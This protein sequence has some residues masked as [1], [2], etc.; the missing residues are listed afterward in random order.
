M[1]LAAGASSDQGSFGATSLKPSSSWEAGGSSGTFSWSYPI[2]TP[3]VAGSLSPDLAIGYS[4][5]ATDGAVSTTNNQASWLGEGFDLPVGFIERKF[6]TC[7]LETTPK[8][9]GNQPAGNEDLCW[10]TE[11]ART[12]NAKYDNAVLSLQGHS[13]A[14]IRVGNTTAWRLQ[15]DDGTR[16]EKIG[17]IAGG[18]ESW[19]VT[20]PDGTQ[21]FFGKGKADGADAPA[22]NSVLKVPVAGNHSGE[23]GYTAGA[24]ASSFT[25][26]PYRWNL[27]YVVATTGDTMTFYYDKETNRYNR[28]GATPASYDRAATLTGIFYGERKGQEA[29]NP[30][31]KVTF[32]TAERC[33]PAISA[34]CATA[35]PTTATMAAWPDVPMDA[36]CSDEFC[37]SIKNAPTFFT[38]KK[39]TDITTWVQHQA[40]NGYDKVDSWAIGTGFPDSGDANS[41]ATLWPTTITQTGHTGPA[42][43]ATLTLP[44]V[45][46][47]PVFKHNRIDGPSGTY[48][49]LRP[50]LARIFSEAGAVTTVTYSDGGC[51]P[52]TLPASAAT[53]TTR[54]FPNYYSATPGDT[55]AVNWFSKYVVT[56]VEEKD[57]STDFTAMPNLTGLDLST[58]RLTSYTYVGSAAWHWDD[59]I[60][61]PGAKGTWNSW[62]G[63]QKVVTAVGKSGAPQSVTEKT[64][65][66]GMYGDRKTESGSTTKTDT[67][68]D[69]AGTKV[70]DTGSY[71]GQLRESRVLK[72]VGGSA[73]S[74]TIYDPAS[75]NVSGATDGL[76]QVA[77][78]DIKTTKTTQYLASGSRTRTTTVKARDSWGQPTQ[79]EDSG[80]SA[81][82]GDETC[83]RTTYATPTGTATAIDL[84]AEESVMPNV[85]STTLATASVISWEKSLYDGATS[86]GGV[87]GPG[88][89]TGSQ[90]LTGSSTR[91]W[92][93]ETTTSF[94]QHGRPVSVTDALGRTTTTTY[95]PATIKAPT[96]TEV[97]SPDPDGT[98]PAVP[99]TGTVFTD[100]RRNQQIKSISAAGEISEADR[101]A[102]GRVT[103]TWLPGRPRTESA[104]ATYSYTMNVNGV[105]TI[106]TNTLTQT[107]NGL[108]YIT[109]VDLLDSLLRPRQTQTQSLSNGIIV[110][111]NFYDSRGLVALT[112]SYI[113]DVSPG[114]TLRAADVWGDVK[115]NVRTVRDY[116]G[117]PLTESTY[118]GSTLLWQTSTVYGGNT[119]KVT[120]PTGGTPTTTTTD[121]QGRTTKL[122]QHL[123]ADSI[124]SYTYTPA[125]AI[126][127]MTDPKGNKWSYTYDLQGNQLTAKDPD[128]G[129]TTSTYNAVNQP[130][131]VKDARNLGV[132]YTYDA[133]DRVTQTTNLA[134][135][136][137][138]TAATFDPATG[139]PASNT[140]YVT[141]PTTGTPVAIQ[142]SIDSYDSAGRATSTTLH[143][144]AITN[145]VPTQL[146]GDYTITNT[147][148]P[149]GQPATTGLPATGPVA[150]ETLTHGYNTYGAPYSLTGAATYVVATGYYQTNDLAGINMGSVPGNIIAAQY[151]HDQ[152]SGRLTSIR[153]VTQVQAGLIDQADYTYDPA[154]NITN[155]KSSLVGGIIDNQCFSYDT[156]RQLKAAWTTPDTG[157]CATTPTQTTLGNGPAPYWSTWT[158]DTIGKTSSRTDKTAT[159][160]ATTTYTYPANSATAVRPHSVTQTVT[161]GTGAATRTYTYDAAGNTL[162]R[163]GPT[164]A[165]QTLTYDDEGKLT[166]VATG[167]T[168]N[169]VMVYDPTGNRIINQEGTQTTL[170]VAGTELTYDTATSATTASRYYTH[171]GT[172]VAVR[173]GNTPDKL[174]S[175]IT[176]H[177]NTPHHQIRNSDS[178]V[179]ASWQNPYGTS[180][181][182]APTTWTGKRGFVGGSNDTTGLIHIGA[183]DY[184]PQLQRFTTVDPVQNTTDPLQWNPY[185]Y[186]QNTPVTLSDPTGEL[187]CIDSCDWDRRRFDPAVHAREVKRLSG[188]WPARTPKRY[189]RWGY[190]ARPKAAFRGK[191]PYVS[192]KSS[193]KPEPRKKTPP[194]VPRVPVLP[195][196]QSNFIGEVTKLVAQTAG[197]TCTREGS[198]NVCIGGAWWL[199]DNQRS[200]GAT[201]GNTFWTNADYRKILGTTEYEKLMR[202][203]D[204]HRQQWEIF[205]ASFAFLYTAAEISGS[206]RDERLGID[207]GCSNVF[208][209]FAGLSDGGYNC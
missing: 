122:T 1:A 146:A 64:W 138:F 21:Y 106:T 170:T 86:S 166:K 19:K 33:D 110:A 126:A 141:D 189:K 71:T 164:G 104:S 13:G 184:D 74:S 209:I 154:G 168:T 143:L 208:E 117:R 3:D 172:T 102:F 96:K 207:A 145:L 200:G 152:A 162:T 65:Y 57:I 2:A 128:K 11:S 194:P 124:T 158:T 7:G 72:S 109:S 191:N 62:R 10:N 198:M 18:N 69:S 134:G 26:Q 36:V 183:R 15:D 52:T 173:T 40:D 121:I 17:T 47:E 176:D 8:P 50:R 75:T 87:T 95:T 101:D 119:V 28:A 30:A 175:I 156:Q 27:D 94:D 197:G 55:P 99:L 24:F 136:S 206:K 118:D 22:T 112:D 130:L 80:D 54:C 98:G 67:I 12:N 100:P 60:L 73:D 105:S 160:T 192:R 151:Y 92:R 42:T 157:T 51:T 199:N 108:R 44:S 35:T 103:A 169:A 204:R 114:T 142:T 91:T 23:P 155:I 144:P 53:N 127:T 41:A 167:A 131:T 182:T 163:P 5:G 29:N 195:F 201:L 56:Q 188:K 79:V 148:G 20:T 185:T 59:T 76:T 140:R 174:V 132:A 6:V 4:S 193:T 178:N 81:V 37:P 165:T 66:R 46:L 180:R 90:V 16:V 97:T 63:Y 61:E 111:D 137:T 179:Q 84:V 120:P 196:D 113:A 82:T 78:T 115:P 48:G 25:T 129:T 186:S 88:F 107:M 83:T 93:T 38:R 125:G 49:M 45:T 150:A 147:F 205:G 123:A 116:A 58:T 139:R 153:S 32:S 202:H 34:D 177:Q 43:A 85:C 9:G 161:T 149:D 203:E 159:T 39:L 14:L 31:A 181:G 135:T 89:E 171:Q 70:N 77:Q 133:L 190:L 68:T 187:A